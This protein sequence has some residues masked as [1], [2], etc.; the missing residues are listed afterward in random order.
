MRRGVTGL[1]GTGMYSGQS[2]TIL[3]CALTVTEIN[4]LKAIVSAQDPK[5]FVIISPA[6]GI[7]GQGF[8]PLQTEA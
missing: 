7:F 1:P 2:H 5:A 6:Q 8:S 4:Q 3:L